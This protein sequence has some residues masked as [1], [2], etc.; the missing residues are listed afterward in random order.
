M[1]AQ[2]AGRNAGCSARVAIYCDY[3]YRRTSDRL[4]A[5]LPIALFLVAVGERFARVTLVG[6][7]D[8]APEAWRHPLPREVGFQAL[9]N[10]PSLSRPLGVLRALARSVRRFWRVLD[11]VDVVWLLGP[12]PLVIPFAAAAALRRR[13]VA[14]GV[15]QDFP[16]Y[17]AARH[18]GRPV[19]RAAALALECGHRAL[20]ALW[21]TVVVGSDLARRYRRARHLLEVTISLVSERDVAGPEAVRARTWNGELTALSVGRLD[22]EK[23]PLLLADVLAALL[24]LDPRWRLVVCGE[25]SLSRALAERLRA[26]GVADRAELRGYVPVERGLTDLYRSS[27]ALLHCS[28]TEG[29]PQVLLEAFAARLPV[30]ATAVGGVPEAAR[31]AALL[32]PP[33]DAGAA[34]AALGRMA[35][36]PAL[37]ERLTEAGAARARAQSLE[38][39]ARS[40]ADFLQGARNPPP[41]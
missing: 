19:L 15:R 34:A 24:E 18:P 3:G 27:H 13:R 37:R 28:W 14:L 21:P 11:D 39:Q 22:P 8:P 32:V 9:P 40:V 4:W 12:H 2:V 35:S 6:R 25:G 41:T 26:H 10:Y 38:G 17:V 23:N 31:G 29:V 16:A 36:D 1:I 33:G 7:L 20:A 30:V 5:E